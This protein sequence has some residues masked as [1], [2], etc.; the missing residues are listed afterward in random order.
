MKTLKIISIISLSVILA[1]VCYSCD[2]P[3]DPDINQ[4][5]L[6]YTS[7][8]ADKDSIDVGET[9]TFYATASGDK[10]TYFWTA[11]AGVLLGSGNEVTF[12]PSPC[13]FGDILITC[14][15]EDKYENSL[16]KDVEVY[17]RE[18]E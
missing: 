3:D 14:T 12:T 4:N 8:T 1:I 10:I 17:V 5:D 15:V 11:S 9:I 2:D 7:L 6:I 18:I 16:T 13:I